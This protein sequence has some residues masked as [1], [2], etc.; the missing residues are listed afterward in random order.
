MLLHGFVCLPLC[1]YTKCVFLVEIPVH[2][3]I[4]TSYFFTKS[5][6]KRGQTIDELIDL[7]FLNNNFYLIK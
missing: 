4:K 3:V 5:R 2:S 1:N 7:I 6:Q